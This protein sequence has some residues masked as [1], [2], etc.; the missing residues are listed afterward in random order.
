MDYNSRK[1]P[2]EIVSAG[3]SWDENKA[4]LLVCICMHKTST[5][6]LID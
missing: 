1:D 5:L 6:S 2:K 4:L 3:A